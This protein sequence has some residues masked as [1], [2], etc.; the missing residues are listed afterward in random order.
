MV[1]SFLQKK[2]KPKLGIDISSS[3]VKI[4]E[5]GLH[6]GA[7]RIESYAVEPLPVGLVVEKNI[8]DTEGLANII[9]QAVKK[10]GTQIK[11]AIAAVAG[12][13]VITRVIQ[14]DAKLNDDEMEMQIRVEA[15]QY[16]PYPLDEVNID[17]MVQGPSEEYVDKVDV[18]LTAC[19]S[20]TVDLRADALVLAGLTP[21]VIDVESYAMERAFNLIADT[22]SG[23]KEQAIAIID[24]GASITTLYILLDGEVIYSREQ[25]FG[26]RQL[27]DEIQRRYGLSA[28]EAGFAKKRGGLP[29]D[30]D[31]EVLA[32]FKEA[33]VQQVIRSLQF[34]FSSSQ[35]NH[36]DHIVLAGGTSAIAGL[37]EMVQDKM[38]T[39]TQLVDPFMDIAIGP[40]VNAAQL[41]EDAPALMI[42][43]GLALR[44]FE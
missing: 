27:T 10:S 7:Y 20:E 12:S 40:R 43:C 32:P 13:A 24:I 41:Y 11:D 1:F 6:Q 39:I 4:L 5:F 25:V 28:E 9:Q 3:A 34:F 23:G 44:S 22:I 16:I 35:Y 15:E 36:V 19:R 37:C 14:L 26:G 30:Y 21:Q 2:L 33:V 38:G 31:S 29:E 17:F 18:L 42:A 8:T